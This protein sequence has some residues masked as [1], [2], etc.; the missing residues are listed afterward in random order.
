M[1][2]LSILP[3]TSSAD[4]TIEIEVHDTILSKGDKSP[5]FGVLVPE[6]QY[7]YYR[8]ELERAGQ[9]DLELLELEKPPQ[10]DDKWL[11]FGLGIIAGG[12]TGF[13]LTHT[14]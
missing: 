9:L 1:I 10:T 12:V 3:R 5:F 2:S 14:K 4:E 7:R 8:S 6:D 11:F 13:L